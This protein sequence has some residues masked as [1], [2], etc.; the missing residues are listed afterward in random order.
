MS[1]VASYAFLTLETNLPETM[2][3]LAISVG[4]RPAKCP[5]ELFDVGLT[6]WYSSKKKWQELTVL[7]TKREMQ[8]KLTS[9]SKK[10][11]DTCSM[12]LCV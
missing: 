3:H 5:Q 2:K 1:S 12:L 7:C 11:R 10:R 6:F 9:S 4:R 8:I